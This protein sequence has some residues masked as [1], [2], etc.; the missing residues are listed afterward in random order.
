MPGKVGR[1]IAA[2]LGITGT[3]LSFQGRAG[4]KN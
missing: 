3:M 2:A 1:K 4:K